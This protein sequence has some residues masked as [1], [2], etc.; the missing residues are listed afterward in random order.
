[1]NKFEESL[2]FY[3]KALLLDPNYVD[4][5]NNKGFAL[6]SLGKSEEAQMCYKSAED[7]KKKVEALKGLKRAQLR[8]G[9]DLEDKV[10]KILE[11]SELVSPPES[12]KTSLEDIPDFSSSKKL[13][14]PQN[15]SIVTFSIP[16]MNE[17][18]K[19]PKISENK[20]P[21]KPHFPQNDNI[22]TFSVPEMNEPKKLPKISE[23]TTSKPHFSQNDSI[24]TF[25]I[26]EINE[27]TKLPKISEKT[28]S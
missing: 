9:N 18:T 12:N 7:A 5:W 15:D 8:L 16:E 27:P 6:Q 3:N 10:A 2:E 24:V 1:M 28:T 21:S 11:T 19:L 20:T 14:F 22:V 17:P 25:S 23:K 13:S 4:A 26:P